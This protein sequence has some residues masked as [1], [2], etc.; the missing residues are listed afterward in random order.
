[1]AWDVSTKYQDDEEFGFQITKLSL[2]VIC[3]T[4]TTGIGLHPVE[5]E[6]EV[7]SENA[8][9]IRLGRM[10]GGQELVITSK[11][12]N[13]PAG[14]GK[15]KWEYADYSRKNRSW[16]FHEYENCEET[17]SPEPQTSCIEAKSETN[18]SSFAQGKLV[19]NSYTLYNSVYP[20]VIRTREEEIQFNILPRTDVGP[21]GRGKLAS[22]VAYD[23]LTRLPR[24][25]TTFSYGKSAVQD[26]L[27]L[28]EIFVED[29]GN[30]GQR[31]QM[32]AFRYTGKNPNPDGWSDYFGSVYEGKLNSI[33]DDQ[34]MIA[35]YAYEMGTY[36]YTTDGNPVPTDVTEK[37]LRCGYR[38]LKAE[39]GGA[40]IDKNIVT[41]YNYA[42][43]G[44][45][46]GE[47][48][49]AE[50]VSQGID[51]ALELFD[52]DWG[53]GLGDFEFMLPV[54]NV[55]Y[56]RVVATTAGKGDNTYHYLTAHTDP[57]L[58]DEQNEYHINES[59]RGRLSKTEKLSGT[60]GELISRT[61]YQYDVVPMD[62]KYKKPE[63]YFTYL[64][65]GMIGFL[66]EDRSYIGT[67][68]KDVP[69]FPE[70]KMFSSKLIRSSKVEEIRDGVTVTTEYEYNGE[71]FVVKEIHYP[72]N[73]LA[74]AEARI[75][76]S[77]YGYEDHWTAPQSDI[78]INKMRADNLLTPVIQEK[79]LY[80][81]AG[82]SVDESVPIRAR[83]VPW[84]SMSR[85]PRYAGLYP[86]AVYVWNGG[87]LNK[88]FGT[89][90]PFADI[91]N[92]WSLPS[93]WQLVTDYRRRS[94]V[95]RGK[96][97]ES[98]VQGG[99]LA[100]STFYRND[101]GKSMGQALNA[102][103]LESGVFTCDYDLNQDGY[104]DKESGWERGSYN[105][106]L[107]SE[108]PMVMLTTKTTHFGQRSVHVKNAY[109]PTRNFRLE[110]DRNYVFSAWV[111][112][113]SGDVKL[114]GDYRRRSKSEA[115]FSWPI[116]NI[117][118]MNKGFASGEIRANGTGEWEMLELTIPAKA[119]LGAE[120]WEN[121]EYFARVYAGAPEG[122]ECWVD[123]IRFFPTDAQVATTYY[124]T[125]WQKPIIDVDPNGNTG[126]LTGYDNFGKA[127]KVWK[128]SANDMAK[129]TL[130][131]T[132]TVHLQGNMNEPDNSI[133]VVSPN[134]GEHLTVGEKVYIRWSAGKNV[135]SVE[136]AY[137]DD[138]GLDFTTID[139]VSRDDAEWGLMAWLPPQGET[140]KL[141]RVRVTEVGNAAIRDVSDGYLKV[142]PENA[143]VVLY[144]NDFGLLSPEYEFV[145]SK[146]RSFTLTA[147]TTYDAPHACASDPLTSSVH[148]SLPGTK[149][150][151]IYALPITG[152]LSGD[153]LR[154][155]F[156]YVVPLVGI[157]GDLYA[158]IRVLLDD[159]EELKRKTLISRGAGCWMTLN[160]G[161]DISGRYVQAVDLE[162]ESLIPEYYEH[163]KSNEFYLDNVLATLQK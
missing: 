74:K 70:S 44:K 125:L 99:T 146:D 98:S 91:S 54:H 161:F 29:I 152:Y 38:V 102:G 25:T 130:L 112:K 84:H 145:E 82:K 42:Q 1:L 136:V 22:V 108:N 3:D 153:D 158:T 6:Y 115:D 71:N 121:Y 5:V 73:D 31:R 17:Y 88:D 134:G 80:K 21:L 132:E 81:P 124:D 141:W 100:Q 68:A 103:Y 126:R 150:N 15:L 49:Y 117:K 110:Q 48:G 83:A 63:T 34:G 104:F 118:T 106:G 57:R 105:D 157:K 86:D 64:Q 123:D 135:T 23:R 9:L 109:G 2:Y 32:Y 47:T 61:S 127:E 37:S 19:N 30:K 58:K 151:V 149:R 137:T 72:G 51:R 4:V 119:D 78:V 159:G 129:R 75:T 24:K 39:V 43:N 33:E 94:V 69:H 26:R 156:K 96:L 138:G 163:Y 97:L 67:G 8:H 65:V 131:S 60:T 111:K 66:G 16:A 95:A 128:V 76:E 59:L 18:L 62:L 144:E 28:N 87:A 89:E 90:K 14:L 45:T 155:G 53:S 20:K 40:R 77:K 11:D 35:R 56:S 140:N 101:I 154:V 13:M 143:P 52:I 133:R 139:V 148:L 55:M 114:S 160:E 79:T 50:V 85:V 113:G 116:T 122:G 162:I 142:V 107:T 12:G 46:T 41:T 92:Y 27:Q 93:D 120:D 7:T 147:G 36:G 10:I